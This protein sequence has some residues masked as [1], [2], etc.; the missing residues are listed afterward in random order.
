MT[1]LFDTNAVIYFLNG[2]FKPI[3]KKKSVWEQ[4]GD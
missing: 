2:M 4:G 3:D 1:Y